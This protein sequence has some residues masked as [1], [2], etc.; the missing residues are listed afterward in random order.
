MTLN[1]YQYLGK[2]G[3]TKKIKQKNNKKWSVKRTVLL[4]LTLLL[5]LPSLLGNVCFSC[6]DWNCNKT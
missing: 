2:L 1:V 3:P 5:Y 6:D 4:P